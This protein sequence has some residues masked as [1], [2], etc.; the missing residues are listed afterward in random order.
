[1]NKNIAIYKAKKLL[2]ELDI[3]NSLGEE[4]IDC[5]FAAGSIFEGFGNELSDVDLFVILTEDKESEIRQLAQNNLE[6]TF[7]KRSSKI[8]LIIRYEN[9]DFDIEFLTK[10]SLLIDIESVNKNATFGKN[11]NFDFWHRIKFAECIYNQENVIQ[12]KKELNYDMFNLIKPKYNQTYFTVIITDIMGAFKSEDIQSAYFLSKNLLEETISGF[13][14]LYGETNPSKK[15]L[16]K[17][18]RRFSERNS[19][20]DLFEILS[21]SYTNVD[22]YNEITL[23]EITK[24]ILKQCHK[25]NYLCEKKIK[26][27][28]DVQ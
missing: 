8:I 24:S 7:Y 25:L 2:N 26:E 11:F 22:L 6:F 18:I 14:S 16:I 19:S 15:W 12:L 9:V 13:L 4:Y 17:K 21:T 10:K 28:E 20:I 1:M 23:T 5:I 3:F 27:L